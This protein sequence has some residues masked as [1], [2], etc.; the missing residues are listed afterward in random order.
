MVVAALPTIA[1]PP[2][3]LAASP[4][5]EIAVFVSVASL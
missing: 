2:N 4:P 3:E 5:P 1:T